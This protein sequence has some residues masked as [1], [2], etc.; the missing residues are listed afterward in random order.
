MAE[1]KIGEA[2]GAFV[3][4]AQEV[5]KPISH[6]GLARAYER[7]GQLEAAAR[8]WEQ[9]LADAGQILHNDF[10]PDLAY[11]DV[12]VGHLYLRMNNPALARSH[13]ERFLHRWQKADNAELLAKTTRE[14]SGLT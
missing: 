14:L 3:A 10:P 4:A 8:E 12:A 9:V 1:G 2:E 13:Y 11:A 6:I 7:E 5:D